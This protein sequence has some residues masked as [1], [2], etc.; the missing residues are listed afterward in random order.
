MPSSSPHSLTTAVSCLCLTNFYTARW[1]YLTSILSCALTPRRLRFCH[2]WKKAQC[3]RLKEV[4]LSF[5]VFIIT[6]FNG[7]V[8][9][10]L[11]IFFCREWGQKSWTYIIFSNA[12]VMPPLNESSLI[13]GHSKLMHEVLFLTQ[14]EK[15]YAR[16]KNHGFAV[17]PTSTCFTS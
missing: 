16:S 4:Y 10:F 6:H 3:L 5:S 17:I 8:K 13:V 2:C 14:Q 12:V 15:I 11:K 9:R 7:K 1:S